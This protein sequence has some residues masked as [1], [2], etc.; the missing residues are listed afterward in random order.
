MDSR[1]K[2]CNT[3]CLFTLKTILIGYCPHNYV[4]KQWVL[5]R[6]YVTL[7]WIYLNKYDHFHISGVDLL[8]LINCVTSYCFYCLSFYSWFQFFSFNFASRSFYHGCTLLFAAIQ[9]PTTEFGALLYIS[10]DKE[11]DGKMEMVLH[12][13]YNSLCYYYKYFLQCRGI[14]CSSCNEK[15]NHWQQC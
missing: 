10:Y 1:L 8:Y 15:K 3:H 4:N 7:P 2:L 12:I 9:K 6:Y 14:R 11:N 13:F 5:Q